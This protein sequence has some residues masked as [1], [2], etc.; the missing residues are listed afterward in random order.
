MAKRMGRALLAALRK[1]P[2]APPVSREGV[3]G[4][5]QRR[6]V[7]QYLCLHP[8]GSIAEA[9]KA[10]RV[11]PATVRFHALR[12]AAA[13][14]V[15]AVGPSFLPTGLVDGEDVP[16]FEALATAGVRRLLAAAFANTG[17]TVTELAEAVGMS[18]QGTAALLDSFESLGL[19][20]R[21][22][23]GRFARVYPTRALE[24]R[25]DRA[26]PRRKQFC[27]SLLRRLESE[28]EAPEVLRKT[29]AVVHVRFGR[30]TSK[31]T[32]E[33]SVEPFSALLL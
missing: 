15:V 2:A 25:R 16:M 27:D 31:A 10:L 13:E 4:N 9:A 7:L 14:Y 11:S 6:R 23:D 19:V 21:V 12:L 32:L 18:R 30:G 1:E 5:P 33:L 8:C 22:A 3:L 29:D 28:G 26:K 20:S 17:L 24:E